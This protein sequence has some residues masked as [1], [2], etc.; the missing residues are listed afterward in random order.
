MSYVDEYD[1]ERSH[2]LER[3]LDRDAEREPYRWRRPRW[4]QP[5]VFVGLTPVPRDDA[6]PDERKAA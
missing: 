5:R 2:E 1:L 6:R 3:R 4:H